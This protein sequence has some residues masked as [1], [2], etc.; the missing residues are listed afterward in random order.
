[1]HPSGDFCEDSAV[2]GALWATPFP[3]PE[4]HRHVRGLRGCDRTLL[5][6]HPPGLA[7][8]EQQLSN[9]KHSDHN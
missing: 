1:M 5:S 4:V 3:V 9:A 8:S 7:L 2:S 6:Q